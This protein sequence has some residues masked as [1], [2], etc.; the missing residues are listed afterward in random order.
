MATRKVTKEVPQY[1]KLESIVKTLGYSS[2]ADMPSRDSLIPKLADGSLTVREAAV[3]DLYVRGI[4]LQPATKQTEIG[5]AFNEKFGISASILP[6]KDAPAPSSASTRLNGVVNSAVKAGFQ[7]NTP[8]IDIIN[9]R[10]ALEKINEVSAT[11]IDPK[12]SGVFR[13]IEAAN[14]VFLPDDPLVYKSPK[15]VGLGLSGAQQSRESKK[16][17]AVPP[18]DK[19][20]PEISAGLQ[21][22]EYPSDR[23]AIVAFGLSPY[24]PGEMVNLRLG[25]YDPQTITADRA[26]GYFDP[27]KGEIVFPEGTQTKTK[28]ALERLKLDRNSVLYN[29][30]MEQARIADLEGSDYL[31]PDVTT[32]TTTDA[33]KAHIT[34]R[35]EQFEAILGRPFEESKDFRKL[36]ASM[37]IYE[38][39]YQAEAKEML[40]HAN[41]AQINATIGKVMDNFY[42]SRI[43]SSDS[44][45]TSVYV[46]YENLIGNSLGVNS[47]N[48][49][50]IRFGLDLPG[51]TDIDETSN[52]YVPLTKKGQVVES[53]VPRPPT[54]EEV[55][56]SQETR[57]RTQAENY[58][59]TQFAIREGQEVELK[60]LEQAE[61]IESKRQEQREQ[62]A[63]SKVEA[64]EKA[65]EERKAKLKMDDEQSDK[66]LKIFG[67][68]TGNK[69]AQGAL[70]VGG[71][72][73]IGASVIPRVAEAQEKIE[74]GRP[75]APSVLEEVGQFIYEESPV[76]IAQAGLEIGTQ[77]VG[78]GIDVI[79]KEIEEEARK[80]GI[81]DQMTG[82]SRSFGIPLP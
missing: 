6:E 11:A 25:K 75:V 74:A 9:S 60:N 36:I 28:G 38:L 1:K 59:A 26:P 29:V 58:R 71:T 40:G 63:R 20:F 8:I 30:L 46:A 53:N 15:I 65:E 23:N 61:Q 80:K 52:N 33:I 78:A 21:Q 2:V 10:E 55:Q 70:T 34:P 19:V 18:P 31:F 69:Y 3:L 42:A 7:L 32:K 68:I 67:D 54:A 57:E 79:Q 35:L 81:D 27:E 4:R 37:V 76:G 51:F 73:L 45:L 39:G 56:D 49:I 64:K 77:A 82:I 41:D 22:I 43:A 62:K 44:P 16:F 12:W 66:F 50:A 47:V 48:D 13:S 14:G 72:A 17:D 24:R 5:K